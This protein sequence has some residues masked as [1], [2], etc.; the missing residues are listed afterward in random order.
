[1]FP[2]NVLPPSPF[3]I[4]SSVTEYYSTF[5]W[6]AGRKQQMKMEKVVFTVSFF[7]FQ[8]PNKALG[9]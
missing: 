2:L 9:D 4:P 3:R 8:Q 6:M 7:L 5:P 1:M